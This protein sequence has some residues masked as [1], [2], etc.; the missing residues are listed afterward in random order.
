VRVD[1]HRSVPSFLLLGGA[2][3]CMDSV[4]AAAAAAGPAAAAIA[5]LASLVGPAEEPTSQAESCLTFCPPQPSWEKRASRTELS[6]SSCLL[7]VELE[8]AEEEASVMGRPF[9][10]AAA[11]EVEGP[12]AFWPLLGLGPGPEI[13]L[14]ILPAF[15]ASSEFVELAAGELPHAAAADWLGPGPPPPPPPPHPTAFPGL[16]AGGGPQ[17][18]V[19][20]DMADVSPGAP[21]LR[22]RPGGAPH[23]ER[24]R[25]LMM[26]E[27]RLFLAPMAVVVCA[28]AG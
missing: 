25:L 21:P 22:P 24:G 15:W 16:E 12:I 18:V 17:P 23:P 20:L 6:C 26:L 4:L 2:C 11:Q 14:S 27:E 19:P 3:H 8:V 1:F 28:T 13:E 10:A 7:V 5:A 9:P